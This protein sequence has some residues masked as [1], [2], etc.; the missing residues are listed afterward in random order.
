MF[1]CVCDLSPVA[2]STSI[3]VYRYEVME[4][5]G[6]NPDET[7]VRDQP[8]PSAA[9]LPDF[10]QSDHVDIVKDAVAPPE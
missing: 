9:S 1:W 5:A 8:G 3:N 7:V 2:F 4:A 6:I 10:P